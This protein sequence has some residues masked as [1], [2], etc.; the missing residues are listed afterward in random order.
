[1]TEQ[2]ISRRSLLKSVAG[3]MAAGLCSPAVRLLRRRN[4][5]NPDVSNNPFPAGASI[6]FPTRNL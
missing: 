6:V 2:N 3:S 4:R 1:M 5:P